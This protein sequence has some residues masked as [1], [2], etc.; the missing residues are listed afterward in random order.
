MDI[1][2]PPEN[3]TK[4]RTFTPNNTYFLLSSHHLTSDI[5]NGDTVR[6]VRALEEISI[7]LIT[8]ITQIT[9]ALSSTPVNAPKVSL[10]KSDDLEGAKKFRLA[11]ELN[12]TF[13]A[14]QIGEQIMDSTIQLLRHEV[15]AVSP[16]VVSY[17]HDQ[18]RKRRVPLNT[19]ST[20]S[21]ISEPNGMQM[22]IS[23][24]STTSIDTAEFKTFYALPLGHA[25][26]L[27]DTRLEVYTL[28]D[29]GSEVL[30]MPKR[31][32]DKLEL[33]IDNQIKWRINGYDSTMKAL[34]SVA[35]IGVCHDI[36]LD[37]DRVEIKIPMYI[38][39]Q[40]LQCRSYS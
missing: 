26:V 32:F 31:I 12:Q 37:I 34:E 3:I 4:K 23:V 7:T 22:T 30:M 2:H 17:L 36:S 11:S 39:G 35:P 18:A 15:F 20:P 14:Y 21:A 19:P 8:Q 38:Y 33:P 10:K 13:G 27:V 5:T 9:P 24:S 40:K 16:K 25:K 28:L 1:I 6:I 29:N